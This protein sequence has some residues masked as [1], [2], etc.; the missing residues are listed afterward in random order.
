MDLLDLN[1]SLQNTP[2]YCFEES[3]FGHK[4]HVLAK[5]AWYT[6]RTNCESMP[7]GYHVL[8]KSEPNG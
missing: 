1:T 7:V 8:S 3:K 4:R 5:L 6:V 2:S